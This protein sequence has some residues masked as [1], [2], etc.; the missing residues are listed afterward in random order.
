VE[1]NSSYAER[2]ENLSDEIGDSIF[3]EEVQENSE[4]L[5]SLV[6]EGDMDYTVCDENVA[7]VN[8]TY[9]PN[10]DVSTAVSF[11]QNLAWAVQ[12][13]ATS[14]KK[15]IDT[16]LIDFKKTSKY[17]IIYNKYFRNQRTSQMVASDYFSLNSGKI[18]AYDDAIKRYSKQIGWDWRL[19]AS[20]IYQESRFDPGAES[21]AGAFGLMQLMPNTARRFGVDRNS[22]PEQHIRAGVEFILWLDNRFKNKITDEQERIK[23]ILASYNIGYGHI[24]DAMNLADKYGNNPVIWEDGV[25]K[26]LLMKSNPE[27]YLDPVV[28]YGYCRGVETYKFVTEVLERY[29]DY[30]NIIS[31]DLLTSEKVR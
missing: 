1:R 30:K 6:A 19:L 20:V 5:I 9:F 23:F 22:S 2:L 31:D 18:S 28:K 27:Y 14:L 4:Q 11:P 21:W 8:Q 13:G 16:W 24:E 29:N 25:D 7:L 15:E 12:K 10:L 3:I 17:A 26:F